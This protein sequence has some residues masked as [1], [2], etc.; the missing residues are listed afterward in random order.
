MEDLELS[1]MDQSILDNTV[2]QLNDVFRISKKDL[3]ET[4]GPIY[5]HLGLTIDFSKN[6]QVMFTMYDFIEDII[7]TNP[8]DMNNTALHPARVGLFIVD[9]S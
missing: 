1:H 8:L 3:V 7:G 2:K 6:N 9:K 4:K 5:K